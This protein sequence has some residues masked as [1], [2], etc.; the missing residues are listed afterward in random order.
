VTLGIATILEARSIVVL[1]AGPHKRRAV[2]ALL[3]APVSEM[4]PCTALHSH[5]DATVV[6]DAAAYPGD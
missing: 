1:A 3:E 4:F 2:R 6:V 5:R